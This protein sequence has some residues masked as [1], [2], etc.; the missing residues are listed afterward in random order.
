MTTFRQCNGCKL[1]ERK[2]TGLRCCPALQSPKDRELRSNNDPAGEYSTP[3][4]PIVDALEFWLASEP[5]QA[6]RLTRISV[7]SETFRLKGI[8]ELMKT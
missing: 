5:S 1:H 4:V 2:T 7:E 8:A 6:T 3:P